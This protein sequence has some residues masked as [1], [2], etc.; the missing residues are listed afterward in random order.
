MADAIPFSPSLSEPEGT[1]L[2]HADICADGL[3][4][5]LAQFAG[6]PRLEAVLC[7]L[8][9]GV[10]DVEDALWQ[11]YTERWIDS[12]VGVQLDELG[13][14]LAFPRAGRTD[15]TYRAFLRARVLVLRSDGS[16]PALLRI[17][18]ALG[19][20]LT[21]VRQE[22]DYPAA[23][24]AILD[25]ALPSDVTGPDIFAMLNAAKAAG[26]RLTVDYPAAGADAAAS[27]RF[28]AAAGSSASQL[29]THAGDRLVTHS[30]DPLVAAV[31]AAAVGPGDGYGNTEDANTGGFY[32]GAMA[33]SE[34]L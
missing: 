23:T 15:E 7:G 32:G 33:S 30:G 4:I 11:L 12:A 24:A 26:V 25:D 29:V 16:W 3:S 13:T 8:L 5:V 28:E 18:E 1:T 6:K 17:L 2:E 27:F 22:P 9:D 19:V 20:E 10:Q 14:V 34:V 21:S 31:P